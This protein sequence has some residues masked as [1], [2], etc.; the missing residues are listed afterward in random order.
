MMRHLGRRR[1]LT[2]GRS[3][4]RGTRGQDKGQLA[5]SRF[6]GDAVVAP[7]VGD[8]APV[9]GEVFVE[10]NDDP[11]RWKLLGDLAEALSGLVH[12]E[13]DVEEDDRRGD[14]AN[15]AERLAQGAGLANDGRAAALLDDAPQRLPEVGAA[16]GDDCCQECGTSAG[17]CLHSIPSVPRMAGPFGPVCGAPGD[18]KLGA[19]K[20]YVGRYR[21]RRR[22]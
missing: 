15:D 4:R 20:R 13:L 2:S 6:F 10:E 7:A 11:Q 3:A 21:T 22:A 9:S 12:D 16:V 5:G 18:F 8:R 14:L 19:M 17:L 1:S